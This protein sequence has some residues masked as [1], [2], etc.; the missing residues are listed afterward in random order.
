MDSGGWHCLQ[1]VPNA[2]Y[3]PVEGHREDDSSS[4]CHGDDFLAEGLEQNLD[5][6]DV[7][8]GNMIG[9]GRPSQVRHLKRII[10]YTEDL[11]ARWQARS[12]ARH[13]SDRHGSERH[14]TCRQTGWTRCSPARRRCNMYQNRTF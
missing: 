4:V 5:E 9:P 10:G 13:E 2:F 12:D 8:A 6:L 14:T 7:T 11:P 3:L 1:S